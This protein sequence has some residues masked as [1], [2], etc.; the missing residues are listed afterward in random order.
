MQ[1]AALGSPVLDEADRARAF[2]YR[3]LG[4][5]LAGPPDS[6]TLQRLAALGGDTGALGEAL[7]ALSQAARE[8]DLDA[9]AREYDALFIGVGRGELMPY[10]SFYLTG[11]LHER[12]LA[13]V[14]EDMARFGLERAV[15]RSDP[16]DHIATICEVMACLIEGI[17]GA[18]WPVAQQSGFFRR[19]LDPW[20]GR[21]FADLEKASSARFYRPVGTLGR[22]LVQIDRDGFLLEG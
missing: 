6:R 16:E 8:T 20:A 17:D 4:S 2:L 5:A 19:H 10:A 7:R 22:L 18:P 12:P 21:L 11:F 9:A 14:R 15:G 1:A 13:R 3:L